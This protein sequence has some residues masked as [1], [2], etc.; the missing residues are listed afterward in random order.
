MH[1]SPRPTAHHPTETADVPALGRI[2]DRQIVNGGKGTDEGPGAARLLACR[3][4]IPFLPHVE[5]DGIDD[6]RPP[7]IYPV[8]L[9]C[10]AA[11]QM[12]HAAAFATIP[13]RPAMQARAAGF[14]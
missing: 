11:S 14:L 3:H 2:V 10:L 7:M 1:G 9:G 6:L 13:R 4:R 8:C 5:V 12:V